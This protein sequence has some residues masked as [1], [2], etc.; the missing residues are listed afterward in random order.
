MKYTYAKIKLYLECYNAI[1]I[2]E[3]NVVL[4]KTNIQGQDLAYYQV[5]LRFLKIEI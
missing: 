4:K 3:K 1:Y 2:L 5:V